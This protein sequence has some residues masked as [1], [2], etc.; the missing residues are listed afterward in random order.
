MMCCCNL[1]IWIIDDDN[2]DYGEYDDDFDF[3]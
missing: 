2:S 1:M 3:W